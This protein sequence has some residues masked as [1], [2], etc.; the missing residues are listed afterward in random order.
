VRDMDLI[1]VEREGKYFCGTDWT[2]GI[3]LN[4]LNKSPLR[5]QA[6]WMG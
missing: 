3:G 2:G 1:W 6:S 4:R 5:A